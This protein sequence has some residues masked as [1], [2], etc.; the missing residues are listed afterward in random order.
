MAVSLEL[1]AQAR[2]KAQ[3]LQKE[4]FKSPFFRPRDVAAG[5]S[6]DLKIL[7]PVDGQDYPA[8]ILEISM[9]EGKQ[10]RNYISQNF[11]FDESGGCKLCELIGDAEATTGVENAALLAKVIKRKAMIVPVLVCNV[12]TDKSG[13]V[14]SVSI[15]DNE[16]KLLCLSPKQA[17]A[18]LDLFTKRGT[19]TKDKQGLFSYTEGKTIQLTRTG[20]GKNNTSYSF[21]LDASPEPLELPAALNHPVDV[22]ALV[23][24]QI[25]SDEKLTEAVTAYFS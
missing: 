8:T 13:A 14:T 22:Y 5:E 2:A 1:I 20:E 18:F 10:Y 12:K 19:A 3:T 7:S 15:L 6:V 23:Q 4:S 21:A 25:L 9:G 11:P 16:P 24:K 17:D